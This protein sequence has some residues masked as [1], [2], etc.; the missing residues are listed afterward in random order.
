MARPTRATRMGRRWAIEAE[1]QQKGRAHRARPFCMAG[2]GACS[3]VL[4]SAAPLAL[5]IQFFLI[6]SLRCPLLLPPPLGLCMHTSFYSDLRNISNALRLFLPLPLAGEGRGEGAKE[7]HG[8]SSPPHPSLSPKGARELK[9]A[10]NKRC[11]LSE[12]VCIHKPSGRG[13]G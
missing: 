5:H 9:L 3:C 2:P 8:A 6:T 12:D 4:H 13:L 11:V 10:R 1:P 7:G